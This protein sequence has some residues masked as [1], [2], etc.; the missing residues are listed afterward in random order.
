VDA[1]NQA[2]AQIFY[3][4]FLTPAASDLA[5]SFTLLPLF[6]FVSVPPFL[7]IMTAV[8]ELPEQA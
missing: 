8:R 4:L 7:Q 6:I 1:L 3:P 2:V 5:A